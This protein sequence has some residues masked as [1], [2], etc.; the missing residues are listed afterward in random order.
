MDKNQKLKISLNWLKDH[1]DTHLDVQKI[2]DVLTSTGLEVE[3]TTQFG[4]SEENLKGVIVGEV[5]TVEMHPN[6]DKLKIT[7]VKVSSDQTLKIVC[8]AS[9]V[10]AGQKVAVATIGAKISPLQGEPYAIKKSKIRGEESFGMLCGETELGLGLD[11]SGIMVLD[12]NFEIG[13]NL[14]DYIQASTD[15]ILE[16]G[17]TPNRA[18]AMSHYGVARDLAVALKCRKIEDVSLKKLEKY[19]KIQGTFPNPVSVEIKNDKACPRYAGVSILG[20]KIEKSPKWL[21]DRL[22]KIGLNSINNIVDITNYVMHD[23]GQPL[24]A[25]DL[26][27][28]KTK[29]L[30][31]DFSQKAQSLET[32]DGEKR[33][34]GQDDLV[35][36]DGE[37]PVALPGVLGGK[38]SAVEDQT[39][40]IFLESANFDPVV[41]R[42]TAKKFGIHSD[43]SFKF[44]RGVDP[45]VCLNG[46]S[47]AVA[48]ILEM[49]PAAQVSEP[50]D[51]Y[52]KPIKAHQVLLR[53]HRIDKLLGIRI[54]RDQ[55][56]EILEN[57]DIE[58][59]SENGDVLELLVPPF[60]V[61]VTR[62]IDVIEELLRIY[63]YN[64]VPIPTNFS[65]T[66]GQSVKNY[67]HKIEQKISQLLVS[68]GC[69]QAMN[70]SLTSA[71]FTQGFN[72]EENVNILNPLS[73]DLAILRRS[74][75]AGLL[76][77]TQY[78]FN[79]KVEI[80]RLFEFGK[81][82]TKTSQGYRENTRLA[83]CISENPNTS[84]WSKSSSSTSF[85]SLK[86]LAQAIL[87]LVGIN[88][89]LQLPLE[90]E[91]GVALCLENKTEL[92][93]IIEVSSKMSQDFGIK[94]RVY[95]ADFDFDLLVE[96]VRENPPV[97][98]TP[99]PK[100]PSS[101][102]DLALL[103]DEK[104]SYES[105]Y[106]ASFRINEPLLKK[107][108]LFDVYQGDKL[109]AGKKSYALRFE[110]QDSE[111]TLD[112]K[113]IEQIMSKLIATFTKEFNAELRN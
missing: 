65:Y 92:V 106:S 39:V 9:N 76:E 35:I 101:V 28:L 89:Y 61:D 82:Y 34:V 19:P 29:S 85:F 100:F 72:Q 36:F 103:V 23:L 43:A 94:Q 64:A 40:N 27:K 107:V 59:I 10:A 32:L 86:G 99:I 90:K 87:S 47:K 15:E 104:V 79:R 93:K 56:K 74:L 83:I 18:D 109:E 112:D 2:S 46:L 80:I 95:Y 69:F 111:K 7:W 57:L 113:Q 62:E 41:I 70:N 31:V 16:I 48:L 37:T 20:V 49:F 52:P 108:E 67:A 5:Q 81:T 21:R 55:I 6:A 88:A 102:K 12:Q 75:M 14:S 58:I 4:S 97:S 11:D 63:G 25:F 50:I 24:H 53:T 78:N 13:K 33:I 77:N 54:H 84:H 98:F 44:E 66:T 71:S 68:N 96:L 45:N 26:D 60:R 17:L 30:V 42:K 22:S 8:G 110:L 105:L 91:S 38:N 1:L 3:G 51:L 73:S